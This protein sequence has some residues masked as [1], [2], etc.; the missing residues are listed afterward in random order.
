MCIPPLKTSE[1]P[2]SMSAM[3]DVVFLLLFLYCYNVWL[4]RNDITENQ[5]ANCK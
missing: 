4:C 3:T 1:E 5:F 2:N